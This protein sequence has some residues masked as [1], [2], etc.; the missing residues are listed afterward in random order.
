MTLNESNLKG[1]IKKSNTGEDVVDLF[2]K[3]NPINL[4]N[5]CFMVQAVGVAV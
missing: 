4:C 5:D 2:D 1:D 3:K